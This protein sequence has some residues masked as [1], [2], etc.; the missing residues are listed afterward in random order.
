VSSGF[1]KGFLYGFRKAAASS[2]GVD[3]F[4][5]TGLPGWGEIS[6]QGGID[7]YVKVLN[8]GLGVVA[9]WGLRSGV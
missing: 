1:R 6:S 4:V 3:R 2:R 8:Y 9:Y 5:L 7:I